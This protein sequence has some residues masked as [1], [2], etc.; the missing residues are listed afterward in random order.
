MP[1]Y[2]HHLI[3]GNISISPIVSPDGNTVY[4]ASQDNNIY[5]IDTSGASGSGPAI[6]WNSNE[7]NCTPQSGGNGCTSALSNS[8]DGLWLFSTSTWNNLYASVSAIH[9]SN[10]EYAWNMRVPYTAYVPPPSVGSVAVTGS[11]A[12]QIGIDGIPYRFIELTYA[13]PPLYWQCASRG[14][15]FCMPS[16]VGGSKTLAACQS[17]CNLTPT[18]PPPPAPYTITA[19]SA[20]DPATGALVGPHI[21]PNNTNPTQDCNQTV[22]VGWEVGSTTICT[23]SPDGMVGIGFSQKEGYG[24]AT[25]AVNLITGAPLWTTNGIPSS[26]VTYPTIS[27]DSKMFYVP[28]T[29]NREPAGR[30]PNIGGYSAITGNKTWSYGGVG[31]FNQSSLGVTPDSKTLIAG[32]TDGFI[33]AFNAETG[34]IKWVFNA[35]GSVVSQ[36]QF[37]QPASGL[38]CVYVTCSNGVVYALDTTNGTEHWSYRTGYP[39]EGSV[40]VTPN[41]TGTK[42]VYFGADDGR[43]YGLA[44]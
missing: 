40:A 2:I 11:P 42:R 16:E 4:F 21:L 3:G 15:A 30:F 23:V 35:G 8:Q 31:S 36:L 32:N 6:L 10:G 24:A 12:V 17:S 28:I 18:P 38:V 5:A 20:F 7:Y 29:D 14:K 33:Y 22:C 9:T 19:L 27:P 26:L 13:A 41:T 25:S 39:I 1:Q 44:A 37:T 43:L 34:A